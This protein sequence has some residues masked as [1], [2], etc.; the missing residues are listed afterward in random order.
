MKASTSRAREVDW[1]CSLLTCCG[2]LSGATLEMNDSHSRGTAVGGLFFRFSEHQVPVYTSDGTIMPLFLKANRP[3]DEESHRNKILLR[4]VKMTR[5]QPD[6]HHQT[7]S[8]DITANEHVSLV[9]DLFPVTIHH[10][11]KGEATARSDS[12]MSQETC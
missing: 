11:T 9:T 10:M 5:I 8:R 2:I 7:E 12:S 3:D 4:H 6:R 1:F